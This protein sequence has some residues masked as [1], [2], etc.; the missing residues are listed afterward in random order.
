MDPVQP[1]APGTTGYNLYTYS[2]NNP[3]TFTDPTGQAVL[4]ERALLQ[5]VR[6]QTF[7]ATS[8]RA[9]AVLAW[10]AAN[11]LALCGAGAAVGGAAYY[12]SGNRT[13][14]D[15]AIGALEGCEAGLS[16]TEL[17]DVLS[18]P[19]ATPGAGAP[20]RPAADGAPNSSRSVPD[21]TVPG[22]LTQ[23]EIDEIQAI[24]D[25]FDTTIDV[26]GSR[27]AGNGRNID[28]P[29]LP[30]AESDGSRG[31]GTRSDIDFRIDSQHPRVAELEAELNAVSNGAGSASR[32]F[33]NN[34]LDGDNAGRQSEAPFIQFLPRS[35]GS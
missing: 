20:S 14:G 12:F 26:V 21:A 29:A 27:S 28:N 31:P 16:I 35:D 4:T 33:S 5:V 19:R 34:P 22:T 15:A 30:L 3:T 25:R 32:E 6:V 17:A 8:A 10:L 7:I 1:G 9:Q 24:S 11:P 18:G 23:S 2:A 13:Y